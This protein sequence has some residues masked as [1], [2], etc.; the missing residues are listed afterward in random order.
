MPLYPTASQ[1]NLSSTFAAIQVSDVVV[2]LHI[3][4]ETDL[5]VF[6]LLET[7]GETFQ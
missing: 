7:D 5:K 6:L 3:Q 2:P 4:W 1:I